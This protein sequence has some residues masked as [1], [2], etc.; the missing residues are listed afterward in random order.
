M[1]INKFLAERTELSRRGADAAITQNR[2][3]LT[4][5]CLL[6]ANKCYKAIL[7][8]LTAQLLARSLKRFLFCLSRSISYGNRDGQGSKTI[9]ELLPPGYNRST[10]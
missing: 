2:V 6:Q 10:P 9:Y 5:N 1:R 3:K 4:A 7:S 8:S